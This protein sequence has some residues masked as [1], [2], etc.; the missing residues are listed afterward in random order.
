MLV[1]V[2][3]NLVAGGLRERIGL[4]RVDQQSSNSCVSVSDMFWSTSMRTSDGAGRIQESVELS[5]YCD[6]VLE[7]TAL[8]KFVQLF[9]CP[10]L[11]PPR[12]WMLAKKTEKALNKEVHRSPGATFPNLA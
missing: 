2:F 11:V 1:A 4:A 3:C 5:A 10:L 12:I 7:S 9:G 8:R 6:C